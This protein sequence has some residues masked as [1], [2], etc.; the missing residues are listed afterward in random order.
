LGLTL[1]VVRPLLDY[2]LNLL[3]CKP[4]IGVLARHVGSYPVEQFFVVVT[5][6][7]AAKLPLIEKF[8]V[9]TAEEVG[10]D[11][12]EERLRDEVVSTRSFITAW[13]RLP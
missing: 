4:H 9:A 12:F 13:A 10:I 7:L 2:L 5:L 8:S 1:R 6:I 11:T 3:L